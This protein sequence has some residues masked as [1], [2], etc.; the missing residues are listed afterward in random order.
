LFGAAAA[1]SPET[2]LYLRKQLAQ[3]C[4]R[5]HFVLGMFRSVDEIKRTDGVPIMRRLGL[6]PRERRQHNWWKIAVWLIAFF[7]L[8]SN[9]RFTYDIIEIDDGSAPD[10]GRHVNRRFI[11]GRAA[12]LLLR[13][14]LSD[15]KSPAVIVLEP[16]RSWKWSVEYLVLPHFGHDAQRIRLFANNNVFRTRC[17]ALVRWQ[18]G[19]AKF[20][21]CVA[22]PFIEPYL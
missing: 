20:E 22:Q 13:A 2:Q 3:N 1:R 7:W 6:P 10:F 17:V 21:G 9:L 19:L 16:V 5:N 8:W 18:S 14:P 4:L 15:A 11:D 12:E